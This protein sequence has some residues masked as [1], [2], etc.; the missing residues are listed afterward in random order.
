M[1]RG[2]YG[3]SCPRIDSRRKEANSKERIIPM[4]KKMIQKPWEEMNTEELA[5]ATKEFDVPGYRPRRVKPTAAELARHRR[6]MA[7]PKVG[8]SSFG[9][10]AVNVMFTMQP[11]LL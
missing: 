8:R 6:A 2:C 3:H 4:R 10:G 11:E 9:D 1:V 5:E 7:K